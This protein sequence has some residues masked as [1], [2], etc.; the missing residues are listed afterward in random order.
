M[1]VVHVYI[2]TQTYLYTLCNVHCAF[3]NLKTESG[4]DRM[5][6]GSELGSRR[7]VLQKK[8]LFFL[9]EDQKE[10]Q[11]SRTATH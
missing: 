6:C 5:D 4:Y 1:H 3:H 11:T 10:S 2:Y 7:S 8:K 9:N